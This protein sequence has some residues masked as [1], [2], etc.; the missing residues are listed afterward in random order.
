[1]TTTSK[2][3]RPRAA[4]IALLVTG[5]LSTLMAV[6]LLA[7][8]AV[9]LVADSEKDAG[10]YFSTGSEQFTTD[11]HAL[12]TDNL[13]VD[14]DGA[15]SLLDDGA[16]GTAR[17]Q[18]TPRDG[19]RVFVGV[20]RTGDVTSYLR[21]VEHTTLTDLDFDPF[22][23]EYSRVGGDRSPGSPAQERFWSASVHGSGQQTLTWDVEDGDWSVVVMNADGS[24]GVNADVKAGA[25]VPVLDEIGWIGTGA[26]TALLIAA[27]ALLTLGV[28]SPRRRGEAGS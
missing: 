5:A 10:G 16:L 24:S 13:D 14:L 17:L 20:A 25:K 19:E 7:I 8:G 15:E 28:R 22:E 4:R 6:G 21:D 3:T 11:T 2:T 26:G 9:A 23:A 1:M 12:V 27:A 18:V